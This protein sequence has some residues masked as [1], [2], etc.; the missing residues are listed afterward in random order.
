M[1][2]LL[3]VCSVLTVAMLF[4]A[5]V[6]AAPPYQSD[7]VC[8]PPFEGAFGF[9]VVKPDGGL[10]VKLTGVTPGSDFACRLNCVRADGFEFFVADLDCGKAGA[11]GVLTTI[12]PGLVTAVN[13]GVSSP[14]QC[15]NPIVDVSGTNGEFCVSGFALR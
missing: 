7:L 10:Y 13:A 6:W 15:R 14:T 12:S 3:F 2:L 8:D 4:G 11:N 5:P 9:T 1:R